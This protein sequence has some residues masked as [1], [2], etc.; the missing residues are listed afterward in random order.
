MVIGF[1]MRVSSLPG[2]PEACSASASSAEDVCCARVDA[3]VGHPEFPLVVQLLGVG[4]IM[5]ADGGGGKAGVEP[6]LP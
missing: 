6:L 1:E 5:V 2:R 4:G 3:A